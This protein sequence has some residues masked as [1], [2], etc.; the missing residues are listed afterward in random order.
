MLRRRGSGQRHRARAR[1]RRKRTS[2]DPALRVLFSVEV[3]WTEVKR[4]RCTRRRLYFDLHVGSGLVMRRGKEAVCDSLVLVTRS[5]HNAQSESGRS[6]NAERRGDAIGGLHAI[7][8]VLLVLRMAVFRLS[9]RYGA[10][11]A[12]EDAGEAVAGRLR[13]RLLAMCGK[14]MLAEV[15]QAYEDHDPCN[16]CLCID[17]DRSGSVIALPAIMTSTDHIAHDH[18][19]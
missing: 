16:D 6:A 18:E 2:G 1:R 11:E 13:E 8:S 3:H 14:N 5:K 4:G 12:G 9:Y 10:T 15:A 7:V 19:Q 17:N